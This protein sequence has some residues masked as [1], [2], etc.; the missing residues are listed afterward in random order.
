MPDSNFRGAAKAVAVQQARLALLF[1]MAFVSF[2]TARLSTRGFPSSTSLGRRRGVLTRFSETK[3]LASLRHSPILLYTR[4]GARPLLGQFRGGVSRQDTR[5]FGGRRR[6]RYAGD[7]NT[8]LDIEEGD[9]QIYPKPLVKQQIAIEVKDMAFGGKGIGRVNTT[10]GKFVVFIPNTIP[11]QK[12]RARVT[13]SKKDFAECKLLEVLRQ[14]EEEIEIPYQRIPG[15][16][17]ASLPMSVQ[18]GYKRNLTISLFKHLGG[19]DNAE[20]LVDEFIASP[21]K[22]HYRNK[23][24]YSFS[25]DVYDV[26]TREQSVGFGLGYKHRGTF[27]LVENLERDSGLFDAELEN[28]MP[29]IRKFLMATELPAYYNKFNSG[30]FRY[31]V[32]RKSLVDD[33]LLINLVTTSENLTRFDTGGFKQLMIDVLGDRLGGLMHTV[34]DDIGDTVS[35][36]RNG[37]VSILYGSEVLRER[38]CGLDF[39]MSINSFFQTNP[40]SAENLYRK[41]LD[42]VCLKAGAIPEGNVVMDLFCGTGTITQLLAKQYNDSEIIGVEIVADAIEDAK[43]NS[44]KNKLTNLQFYAEDVNRFLHNH[45]EYVGAIH[46]IVLDPPRAGIAP[47]A[48]KRVIELGAQQIVYVSCNP[49]TQVRDAQTLKENGYVMDRF[50]MVDQF[51]H[52]SHIETVALFVKENEV[53]SGDGDENLILLED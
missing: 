10:L 25:R 52:T 43:V 46:T 3:R 7:P 9:Q 30:F 15:A 41:A 23:V 31:L 48:L 8:V 35:N 26:H 36:P 40:K 18:E 17:Y 13:K 44:E 39:Q 47:K 49:A 29:R 50:S 21:S 22:W 14:S 12:V 45:P 42:Y 4:G 5:A 32:C 2:V 53:G 34:N 24:E 16:P 37:S 11:G 19:I 1:A 20:D 28:N 6:R 51:P 38:V 27:W 33:R